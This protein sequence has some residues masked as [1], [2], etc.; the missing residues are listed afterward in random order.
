MEKVEIQT[1]IQTNLFAYELLLLKR[2]Y[3]NVITLRS[4]LCYRESVCR[5]SVTF[6]HPTHG[7]EAFVNISTLL[8]TLAT[9]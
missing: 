8:C 4:G 1:Y 5:L 6:V 9:F 2:F 3:P 7:I